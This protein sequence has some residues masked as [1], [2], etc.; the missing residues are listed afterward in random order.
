[1]QIVAGTSRICTASSEPA[2]H[3]IFRAK[4]PRPRSSFSLLCLRQLQVPKGA[5]SAISAAIQQLGGP[6]RFGP[7]P[8]APVRT[9]VMRPKPHTAHNQLVLA[10]QKVQRD[11]G[12]LSLSLFKR[13]KQLGSGDVGLVDLVQLQVAQMRW[14]QHTCAC[15]FL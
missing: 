13:V 12:K 3:A 11:N 15:P 8:W 14:D 2:C 10:L 5:A 4:R 1:M 7:D 6:A 9:G